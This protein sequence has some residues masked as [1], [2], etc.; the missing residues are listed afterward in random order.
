MLQALRSR[1]GSYF[2]K[3]LFAVLVGSFAIW[4]IGDVVRAISNPDRPAVVAGSQEINAA[5]IGRAFQAQVAQL[6]Q[7]FGQRF[8]SEQAAQF[9]LLDQTVERLV[10]NSLFDQEAQRLGIEVGPEVIRQQIRREPAFK[11]STGVFTPGA[12]QMALRNAGMSEQDYVKSIRRD[13]DRQLVAGAIEAGAV[14]PKSL[15]MAL[16]RYRS[17]RRT[18]DAVQI[19]HDTMTAIPEPTAEELATFHKDHAPQ[20]TAPEYRKAQMLRLAVEELAATMPVEEAQIKDEYDRNSSEYQT[21][22]KREL[23][24]AL[25][26]EEDDAKKLVEAAKSGDF[27]TAAKD[28]AKLD[29]EAIKLGSVAKADLPA[30]LGDAVFA[31]PEGGVTQ[32]I[33]SS[34]GWHVFKVEKV[35]PATVRTIDEVRDELKAVIAKEH[36]SDQIARLSVKLED[37]I[38]GGGTF[39]EAAKKLNLKV[40]EIGPI[41][42]NGLGPDGKPVELPATDRAQLLNT[43]FSTEA[44]KASGLVETDRG[45][46]F[47]LRTE[48]VTPATLKPIDQVKDEVTQAW[49]AEKRAA[50]AKVK[51]D[52]VF[53][54][55]KAANGDLAKVAA[56]N[57]L[58]VDTVG[59]VSRGGRSEN[60]APQVA[61]AIFANKPGESARA[62][63]PDAEVVVKV[64]EIVPADAAAAEKE[65][66]ELGQ[67]LRGQVAQDLS[68][69]FGQGLRQ[70]YPVKIDQQQIQKM[71]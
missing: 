18:A 31:A 13:I 2:I 15:V 27:A 23:L 68:Q 37:E 48:A 34:L 45:D 61:A 51:A 65:V 60:V 50:A 11:D 16:E 10:D 33:K 43:L 26:S 30:D 17:E 36:A 59:P 21:P 7:R 12:F 1:L 25:V 6:R 19:R 24:Q 64:K 9:G 35:E 70:R 54:K 28:I 66:T 62:S 56:E 4:G 8:T 42:R 41:D 39:E 3:I 29:A 32:P 58:N 69:S 20:F 46:F 40:I 5:E 47:V 44:A 22:E 53:A 67:R 71:Y 38:V 49:L 14:P 57:G 55:V 52:E 63:A